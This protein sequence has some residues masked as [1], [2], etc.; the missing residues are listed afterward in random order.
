MEHYQAQNIS[1]FILS[2][3]SYDAVWVMALGLDY[4]SEKVS[5]ND[6]NG[7]DHLPGKLVP[8]ENFDYHNELMGC[9]LKKS[10]HQVNFTGITVGQGLIHIV[11]Y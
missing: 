5:R 7:C 3:S 9:V 4:A 8:L 1:D 6:S 11:M 2:G 10:F